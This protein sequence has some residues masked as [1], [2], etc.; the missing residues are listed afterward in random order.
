MTRNT[1]VY[2]PKKIVDKKIK[3]GFYGVYFASKI[4]AMLYC[5]CKFIKE[6]NPFYFITMTNFFI[7]SI[8]DI[9]CFS[10]YNDVEVL[11]NV[12]TETISKLE[13]RMKEIRTVERAEIVNLT[14]WTF[15]SLVNTFFMEHSKLGRTEIGLLYL[16]PIIASSIELNSTCGDY[17]EVET[18]YKRRVRMLG[19]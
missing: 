11:K 2:K 17:K 9:L 1:K 15:G 19:R 10:K 7:S 6:N 14:A 13:R 8:P 4:A 3:K 12:M 16:I 18:E 5:G